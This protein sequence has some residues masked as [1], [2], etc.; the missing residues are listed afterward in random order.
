MLW[1]AITSNHALRSFG[2]HVHCVSKNATQPPS[3]VLTVAV[4][5][6][7]ITKW[8][9]HRKV[10]NFWPHLCSVCTLGKLQDPENHKL[11][12]KGTPRE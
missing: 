5:A 4:F 9:F 11:S 6:A 10:V 1:I 7:K 2:S 8:I 12:S 3:I